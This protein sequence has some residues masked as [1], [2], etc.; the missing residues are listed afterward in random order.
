MNI[1]LDMLWTQVGPRQAKGKFTVN[2]P[3]GRFVKLKAASQNEA[4]EWMK[5]ITSA[6]ARVNI[7]EFVGVAFAFF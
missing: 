3:S 6:S 4:D 5:Q 7:F 1:F 2:H